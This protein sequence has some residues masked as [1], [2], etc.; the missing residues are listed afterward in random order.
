MITKLDVGIIQ[1]FRLD[2]N[3]FKKFKI[4]KKWHTKQFLSR[5]DLN[6]WKDF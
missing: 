3:I 2:R 5:E 1:N 6:N 4:G